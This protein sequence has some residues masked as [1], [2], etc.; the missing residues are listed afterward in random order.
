[1]NRVYLYHTTRRRDLQS[2]LTLG[3]LPQ[4][5]EEWKGL[6]PPK[7]RDTPIIWLNENLPSSYLHSSRVI[8]SIDN[9][10]LNQDN[11]HKLNARDVNWW[12]YEGVIKPEALR[13]IR[14]K[15]KPND[16]CAKKQI[17]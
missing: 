12:V 10:Y 16:D 9:N 5:P 3:L 13:I 2:I 11:L 14:G 4:L 17:V 15:V 6:L 8:L 1:M 7:L